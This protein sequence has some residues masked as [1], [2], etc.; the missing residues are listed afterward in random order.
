MRN[1]NEIDVN[2]LFKETIRKYGKKNAVLV[3]I[4]GVVVVALV[5]GGVLINN[6]FQ[7]NFNES[8][9]KLSELQREE[10]FINQ[11]KSEIENLKTKIAEL[12]K[13]GYERDLTIQTTETLKTIEDLMVQYAFVNDEHKVEPIKTTKAL[14]ELPISIEYIGSFAK[15]VQFIQEL[16]SLKL[17]IALKD[18]K[19]YVNEENYEELSQ[20]GNIK[21][22]LTIL[23]TDDLMNVE[24]KDSKIE[25]ENLNNIFGYY[26]YEKPK[27][28]VQDETNTI[29]AYQQYLQ[30]YTEDKEKEE[31]ESTVQNDSNT[32]SVNNLGTPTVSS[33]PPVDQNEANPANSVIT[34]EVSSPNSTSS[35]GSTVSNELG[36]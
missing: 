31:S 35:V 21:T 11:N 12:E 27:E 32:N 4:N 5:V 22:S 33:S 20:A 34:S 10:R 2:E 28:E 25:K 26:V 1:L 17:P 7:G 23:V 19:F 30:Q 16:N 14:K 6:K 9:E 3:A 15:S 36:N 24:K 29:D 18:L 13:E 8:K